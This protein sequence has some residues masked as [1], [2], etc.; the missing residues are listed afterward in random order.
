MQ[1]YAA[2]APKRACRQALLRSGLLRWALASRLFG[3]AV[4]APMAGRQPSPAQLQ[5][6]REVFDRHDHRALIPR[7]RR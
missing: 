5:V 6:F 7:A 4:A 1:Y 3:V 2:S